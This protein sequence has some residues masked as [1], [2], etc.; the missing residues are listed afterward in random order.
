MNSLAQ[1]QALLRELFQLDLADLDFGLYRLLHLKRKEVE[2]FLTEQLPRHVEEAF[3]GMV[4]TERAALEKEVAEL[5]TRVR[6]EVAENALLEDGGPRRDH[7]GFQAKVGRQLLD[8]YEAKRN[9]LQAVQTTE[10]QKTEV[11]NHLY[12]FLSRYFEADRKSVV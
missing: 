8:S 4:G 11:F 5:A 9:Q 6:N 10:A 7:P 3:Q 12:A 1:F 2:T